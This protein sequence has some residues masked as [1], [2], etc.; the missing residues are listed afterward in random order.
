[1]A[2][3]VRLAKDELSELEAMAMKQKLIVDMFRV[4]VQTIQ[5][6]DKE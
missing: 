3:T 1:M 2:N 6:L 4:A 5:E